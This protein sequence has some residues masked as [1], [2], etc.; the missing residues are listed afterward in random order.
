MNA[1]LH[2]FYILIITGLLV[3]L[4]LFFRANEQTTQES[5]AKDRIIAEKDAVISYRTNALGQVINEKKAIELE[6]DDLKKSFPKLLEAVNK[7]LEI[8]T[9]NLM[10]AVQGTMQVHGE[11]SV[12]IIHDIIRSNNTV[13]VAGGVAEIDDGYLKMAGTIRSDVV[14]YFDYK[15]DYSDVLI[16]GFS[17][18][19]SFFKGEEITISG[20]L[21]NPNAKLT[22]VTGVIVHKVK[23][24][25]FNVS[26]GAYW[27]PLRQQYGPAIT[28]GYSLIRF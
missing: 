17:K 4:F 5:K 11:G 7:Q 19:K 1:R 23:P 25:R 20:A 2:T 28:A 14:D 12:K 22:N 13:Q 3:I 8:K 21:K 24:K 27:D 18:K 15:Y 6:R 9:K 26:V 10:A 16:L